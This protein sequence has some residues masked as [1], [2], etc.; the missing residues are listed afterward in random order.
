MNIITKLTVS[1]LLFGIVY[2]VF[3]QEMLYKT[4][5]KVDIPFYDGN[6]VR[7]FLNHRTDFDTLWLP[8]YMYVIVYDTIHSGNYFYEYHENGLLKKLSVF[9]NYTGNLAYFCSYN[10]TYRDPEIDIIDTIF[11][12][13]YTDDT[14]QYHPQ[15]RWYYN[16]RQADSSYWEEYYQ[17]WDGEK[18]ITEERTYVH[19]LDTATVS[20]FQDHIEVLDRN[21]NLKEYRKTILTFDEKGNVSEAVSDCFDLYNGAYKIRYVY[22]YDEEGLCYKRSNYDYTPSGTWHFNSKLTDI[23]WLEFHGFDNGDL[24]FHGYPQGLYQYYSPKNKNKMSSLKFWSTYGA[25]IVYLHSIDTIVWN[26]YPFSSHYFSYSGHNNCLSTHK[27]Y[28]YN[29]H[30]HRISNQRLSYI[31]YTCDTIPY[32]YIGEDFINKYDDRERRYEYIWTNTYYHYEEDSIFHLTMIYIVDSFTYVLRP[33]GI[34]E[35]PTE[36]YTLLIVPNPSG[37]SVRITAADEIITVSFYA[38]DGR[39]AYSHDGAGKEMTVNIQGLAKGVYV[40]QA[41]LK[42][43]GVQTGKVVVK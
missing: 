15:R 24:L 2:N 42:N 22:L 34:P 14:G 31:S 30:F 4:R 39:L 36:K 11:Y 25:D 41:R 17:V 38:S 40:V 13:A 3:P 1:I 6:A 8:A 37:E 9:D 21:G 5:Q 26:I 43:G 20:E 19:L 35:L 12:Y 18:W 27:Y 10:N 7:N 29:E 28:E 33:V 32:I 23:K 16:N